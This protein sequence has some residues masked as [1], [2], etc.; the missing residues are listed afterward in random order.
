MFVLEHLILEHATID[1]LPTRSI[2]CVRY[3]GVWCVCGGGVCV[4]CEGGLCEFGKHKQSSTKL[5]KMYSTLGC[6]TYR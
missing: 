6:N 4:R 2:T 3:V 5:L 1:G